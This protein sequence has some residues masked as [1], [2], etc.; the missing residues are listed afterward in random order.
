MS[1]NLIE[2]YYNY[3][4]R[5]G[6]DKPI[7][8]YNHLMDSL[9]YAVGSLQEGPRYAVIGKAARTFENF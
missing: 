5:Q 8:S 1:S 4:Y 2:E 6:T 7:D 3:S 9:R